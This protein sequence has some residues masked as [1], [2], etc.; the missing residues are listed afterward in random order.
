MSVVAKGLEGIIANESKLSKVEG[1]EGKL[2]YLGYTIDDLVEHASFEEVIYLLHRGKLP[3]KSELAELTETLRS[4]RSLPE[5]VV[6]FLEALPKT[7]AR[8]TSSARV[9]PCSVSSI[10]EKITRTAR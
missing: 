3:N 7:R 9:S 2:S 4:Q 1:L 8:W 6:E 10:L 5:G